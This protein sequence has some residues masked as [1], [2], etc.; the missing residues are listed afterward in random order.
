[1]DEHNTPPAYEHANPERNG[2]P[3]RRLGRGLNALL[4]AGATVAHQPEDGDDQTGHS[5]IDVDAIQQNPFQPRK[6]FNAEAI[7]ELAESIKQ[8]G[9]L[10]PLLVRFDAGRYQLIAGE[11]RWLAAKKAG[12]ETV[13]CRI[14]ELD[15]QH[16]CEVALEE[17]LKRKDLNV[18]EKAQAFQDYLDRFGSSIEELAKQ[19]SMNRS[20]LSNY[21]RLLE[22]PD[23]VKQSLRTDA[24]SNGHARA[25]LPLDEDK[26]IALCRRI[27]AESLS[28]RKTEAIVRTHLKGDDGTD[29][30]GPT[31]PI[32]GGD[33]TP[34]APHVSNHVLSLQQQ[35]QDHL[36]AKVE[37]RVRGKEAGKII[38]DFN[39]ND[40]FER[41]VRQL[42][43]A[44]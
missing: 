39:S 10:Q 23:V 9:I 1:M 7:D 37:I 41:I 21:L 36:G 3:R 27:Q 31:I 44:A 38:I 28:V 43:R 34:P 5:R 18:L 42:R 15:D 20:T 29:A 8:H 33:Q 26:Q 24:I 12:L 40:E 13:P 19:L 30:G 17:N 35:L 14:L 6:D 32:A 4:G 16:V 22:L 2:L 25:L 11:R